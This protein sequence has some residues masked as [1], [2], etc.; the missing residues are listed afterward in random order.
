MKGFH[1]TTLGISLV[2]GLTASLISSGMVLAEGEV[3]PDAPL[4][5]DPVVVDAPVES[6]PQVVAPDAQ[7]VTETIPT[8]PAHLAETQVELAPLNEAGEQ[9]DLAS[10]ESAVV[11]SSGDPWW[12]VG[13][14]KYAT[15]VSLVNCPTGTTANVTCWDS[16]TPINLA[17]TKINGGLLPTDRKLYVEAGSYSDTINVNGSGSILSQ[18]KGLVG[19]DGSENTNLSGSVTVQNV[20]GGFTL[21]GFDIANFVS[22]HDNSGPVLLEDLY[23]HNSATYGINVVSHKGPIK[24]NMVRAERNNSWGA[25]LVNTSGVASPITVTDSSFNSNMVTS[26]NYVAFYVD[27]N[28]SVTIDGI[29][30]SNNMRGT[31]ARIYNARSI[32]VKNSVFSSNTANPVSDSF[33]YGLYYSTG[34]LV[35]NVTIENVVANYN[36]NTGIYVETLGNISLKNV[37]ASHNTKDTVAAGVHLDNRLGSAPIT[38]SGTANQFDL[39]STYGLFIT[40]AGKITLSNLNADYNGWNGMDVSNSY[41]SSNAPVEIKTGTSIDKNTFNY[42]GIGMNWDGILVNSN[43]AVTIQNTYT[44]GNTAY[45]LSLQNPSAGL[46]RTLNIARSHFDGNHY[47]GANLNTNSPTIIT[48]S[49][50]DDNDSWGL[51]IDTDGS[52]LIN[53]TGSAG[54][55]SFSHN[56]TGDGLNI[57]ARKTIT[58]KNVVANFNGDGLDDHGMELHS[59]FTPSPIYLTNVTANDNFD[60]GVLAVTTSSISVKSLTAVGNNVGAEL[61]TDPD[62]AGNVTVSGN[63]LFDSNVTGLMIHSTGTVSISGVTAQNQTNGTGIVVNATGVGKTVTLK[64]IFACGNL[65]DG[66]YIASDGNMTLSSVS[67]FQNG[68]ALTDADGLK[69]INNSGDTLTINNSSFMDNFGNGLD[70]NLLTLAN[71][72]LNNVN[73]FGNDADG[74]GNANLNFH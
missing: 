65:Y 39:N 61:G 11:L 69:V 36:T 22:L 51:G 10:Q 29:S 41:S 46:S 74:D 14:Q 73:Y 43:G 7:S 48:D 50:A 27:T 26:G 59:Y 37:Q 15:V 40:S 53:C 28:G 4:P 17:L 12:K 24:L 9:L 23:V 56:V 2:I 49:G 21:K 60:R 72:K 6:V 16:S 45:G 68:T 62:Y 30:A 20:T 70:V 42:N 58:I 3:P 54:V 38:I 33:G 71:L 66:I 19:V 25:T 44:I 1:R 31:G 35:S 13:T 8:D 34:T 64:N 52:V 63:S 32:T 67:A 5:G 55:C 18:M 47:G 57:Y